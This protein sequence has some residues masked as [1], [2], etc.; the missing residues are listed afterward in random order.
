[1]LRLM[2]GVTTL[3][4]VTGC[5]PHTLYDWGSYEPSIDR[6]YNSPENFRPDDEVETLAR[7]LETTAPARIP[8]GKAAHVGYLYLLK[9]DREAAKAFFLMEKRLFPESSVLMDRLARD[10]SKPRSK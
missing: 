7:E 10:L 3:V 1:M 5:S 6:M 8:P 9:G 4:L 2:L